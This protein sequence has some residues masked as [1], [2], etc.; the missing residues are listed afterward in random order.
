MPAT[1]QRLQPTAISPQAAIQ[2]ILAVL[3]RGGGTDVESA[4]RELRV[5]SA[6]NELRAVLEGFE[7]VAKGMRCTGRDEGLRPIHLVMVGG[8]CRQVLSKLASQLPRAPLSPTAHTFAAFVVAAARD[9]LLEYR[10]AREMVEGML[11]NGMLSDASWRAVVQPPKTAQHGASA[12]GF[13]ARCDGQQQRR[14]LGRLINSLMTSGLGRSDLAL[15]DAALLAAAEA[16]AKAMHGSGM[17][18][19]STVKRA[20]GSTDERPLRYNDPDARGDVVR[21]LDGAD[22]RY[23]ATAALAQ[24]L[25]G[26]LMDAVREACAAAPPGT[27]RAAGT[28]PRLVI[29]SFT[30]LPLSMLACYPGGGTRF[31]RHVDNSADSPDTRA[32][33]AILYLNSTWRAED[34]GALRVYASP[35]ACDPDQT[36]AEIKPQRGTLVLF[37]SHRMPHE[38]M[39]ASAPRFALSLWMCTSPQQPAGW[40]TDHAA[41]WAM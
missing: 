2:A 8:A 21:W 18:L 37:W 13:R 38:V 32:C 4:V 39:P 20:K 31:R 11:G 22:G 12:D 6:V 14:E 23:P 24:W 19:P 3:L 27:N 9:H 28:A 16:E 40:L 26:E 15:P 35:S 34:G 1:Q 10:S 36:Y 33:T 25:R 5:E 7:V 29:D 41:P 17:L 30:S